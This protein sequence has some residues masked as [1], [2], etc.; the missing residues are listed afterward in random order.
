MRIIAGQY[1]GRK[2]GSPKDDT[3]RPASDKVRGAVFNMLNA[4]IDFDKTHALD[5]FCGTGAYGLEALSRGAV[6]CTFVDKTRA[7][8]DLCKRNIENLDAADKATCIVSDAKTVRLDKH[9]YGLIF[10]DPP[11]GLD[12]ITPTLLNVINQNYCADDCIFVL[13]TA[14]REALFLPEDIALIKTRD[15]GDTTI[16]LAR[17]RRTP[18]PTK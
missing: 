9:T 1:G 11:Y 15:Y 17:Y 2:L 14:K 13:E 5:L 10:C 4:H 7:S 8:L 16:T 6:S 3:I 18:A 12:L